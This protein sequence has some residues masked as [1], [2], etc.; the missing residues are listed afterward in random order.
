MSE[1]DVE[2]LSDLGLKMSMESLKEAELSPDEELAF[3]EEIMEDENIEIRRALVTTDLSD[4]Q[5][6]L[7]VS[8]DDL[9][10]GVGACSGEPALLPVHDLEGKIKL[11]KMMKKAEVQYT[12]GIEEILQD[13]IDNKKPLEVTHTVG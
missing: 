1:A 11:W 13:H 3:Q 9:F 12:K 10:S 4:N 2:Q 5:A 8:D 7:E 6:F